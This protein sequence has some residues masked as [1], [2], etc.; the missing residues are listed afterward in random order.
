MAPCEKRGRAAGGCQRGTHDGVSLTAAPR[1]A[2]GALPLAACGALACRR[3]QQ[4]KQR[5]TRIASTGSFYRGLTCRNQAYDAS[6]WMHIHNN[7][8][9]TERI[10]LALLCS[11]DRSCQAYRALA[12]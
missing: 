9:Y 3:V 6:T 10:G 2:G 1:S 8:R 4:R 12:P 11:R 5:H 7:A